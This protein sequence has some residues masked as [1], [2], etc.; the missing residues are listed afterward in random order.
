MTESSE[1]DEPQDVDTFMG[2]G[3]NEFTSET[4]YGIFNDPETFVG[5]PADNE[6]LRQRLFESPLMQDDDVDY[7]TRHAE[8]MNH[9][10]KRDGRHERV[11]VKS[12]LVLETPWKKLTD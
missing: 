1:P 2:F 12:R 6:P 11:I 3:V 4:T 8:L 7:V 5:I 9:D 10:R